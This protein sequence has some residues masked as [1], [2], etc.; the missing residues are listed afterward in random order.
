MVWLTHYFCSFQLL[1]LGREY[2][3]GADYFNKKLKAE[4]MKN[5]DVTDPKE[6]KKLI[7][8]GK[9]ISKEIEALYSLKKYRTL[10]RRYYDDPPHETKQS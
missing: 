4:F 1:Y 3:L 8:R 10:K 6:I 7:A 5:K 9:Y 2:P